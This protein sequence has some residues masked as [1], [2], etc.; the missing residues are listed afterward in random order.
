V[1]SKTK[2]L[3]DAELEVFEAERDLA[4]ELLTAIGEMKAGK[5]RVVWPPAL[6]ARRE[7][8]LTQVQFA[9]LLGVSVRGLQGWEQERKT[10]SGAARTLLAVARSPHH[11]PATRRKPRLR[12]TRA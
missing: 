1:P 12:V 7:T 4:A 10:P 3:T 11:R 8:G 2:P 5:G 6:A 9:K